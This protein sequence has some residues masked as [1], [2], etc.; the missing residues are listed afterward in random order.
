MA[1]GTILHDAGFD[2]RNHEDPP[3]CESIFKKFMQNRILWKRQRNGD[4]PEPST[5]NHLRVTYFEKKKP[6]KL[7][8]STKIKVKLWVFWF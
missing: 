1:R 2:K 7:R 3:P 5:I 8:I 6:S 4:Q